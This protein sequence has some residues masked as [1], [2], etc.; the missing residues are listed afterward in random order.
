MSENK[1]QKART[2]AL[3]ASILNNS[4]FCFRKIYP[5]TQKN[6]M[7]INSGSWAKFFGPG[8]YDEISSRYPAINVK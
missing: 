8:I 4:V 5:E 6:K 3:I 1:F 2:K 7:L